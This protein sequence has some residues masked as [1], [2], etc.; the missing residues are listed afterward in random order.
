MQ[1]L[2]SAVSKVQTQ[3]LANPGVIKRI[4]RDESTVEVSVFPPGTQ[5]DEDALALSILF[6]TPDE[7]PSSQVWLMSDN[8]EVGALLNSV[9]DEFVHGA[10]LEL[11][12]TRILTLFGHEPECLHHLLHSMEPM[13][14]THAPASALYSTLCFV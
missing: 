11:V 8:E 2:L 5:R 14:R 6:V 3:L 9:A 1:T 13:I 4:S 7:Y 12:L 10:T